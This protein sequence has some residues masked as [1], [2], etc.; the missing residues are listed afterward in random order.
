ME[1]NAEISVVIAAM[2]EEDG[3]G[4]TLG[5]LQRVLKDPYLLVV[6]GNSVDRTVEIAK[7]MGAD[8]LLQEGKGKGDAMYQGIKR[9]HPDVRYVVFTDADYTYPAEYIPKMVEVLEQNPD[10]GMVIGNRFDGDFNQDKASANRFYVGNKLLAFAQR[11]INGISLRDPL[12]GLRIVRT[13]ILRNWEPKS[14]G[15]DV[16][17][18][19]NAVVGKDHKIVE[20]PINYRDR[21]GEKKL[22]LRHGIGILKRIIA[23]SPL[24]KMF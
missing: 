23:E 8:I 5:E 22:R 12:S 1:R 3:I 16:E 17:A 7:N 6:D 18:E 21:L 20:I 13:E 15:F 19:M 9:L 4:L 2:N 11:W 14:K 10:V 24:C